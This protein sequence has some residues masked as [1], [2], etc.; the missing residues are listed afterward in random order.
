MSGADLLAAGRDL[1]AATSWHLF[2]VI[3]K[4]PATLHGYL[5]ATPDP[6]RLEEQLRA[7][8]DADGLAVAAGFSGLAILDLDVTEG[9]DGRDTLRERRFPWCQAETPRAATPRGGEHVFFSG[10][11]PSRT[12]LLAGVDVKSRG[13]YVV[14]P[15]APG[16]EW[17][18][19]AAP[20]DVRPAPVPEWLVKLAVTEEQ[21]PATDPAEWERALMEGVSEPGRNNMA[22][23]LAGHLLRRDINARVVLQLLLAVNRARF[24]PPLEDEE[25]EHVVASVC[26][27]E[28][29]RREGR[30][31]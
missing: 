16:R 10:S 13:G 30:R 25:I 28:A 20:F 1:L 9:V 3:G 19:D 5:D 6:K 14:I 26:K 29:E 12:A 11:L 8:P 22:T 7:A 18:A 21:R 23:R 4:V 15:P 24:R 2:P 27:M 17:Y 31:L